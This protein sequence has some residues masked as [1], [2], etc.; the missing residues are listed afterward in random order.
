MIELPERFSMGDN[1]RFHIR[2]CSSVDYDWQVYTEGL[3][4]CIGC[5]TE[6]QAKIIAESLKQYF[7]K[8]ERLKETHFGL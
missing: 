2:T 6:E 4:Y 5:D 8:Q 1:K 7:N 3:T